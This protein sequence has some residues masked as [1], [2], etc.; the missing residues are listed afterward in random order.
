MSKN[1]NPNQKRRGPAAAEGRS[2]ALAGS[3]SASGGSNPIAEF[4]ASKSIRETIESVAIAFVLA[5]LFRTFEAEAFVIPTGSM[6]HTL[7]GQH[8]DVQCE[9]CGYAHT[10][11]AS[12]SQIDGNP[13]VGTV[14]PMCRYANLFAADD[15]NHID[16]SGD[17]IIV[18]KF[19]YDLQ[20][21]QRWDVIVFK[22]PY[23]A[24]QNYIKRLVGL[25]NE[26]IRLVHGDVWTKPKDAPDS[27]FR[28]ARKPP[29]KV[30]SMQQ[31]VHDTNFTPAALVKN[32]RWPPRW[33]PA[34]GASGA[35]WTR[36][37][38][39][40]TVNKRELIRST[41]N[42]A[43]D[44][45]GPSWIRY[46]HVTPNVGMDWPRAPSFEAADPPARLI[47]DFY[48]YNASIHASEIM[49][50]RGTDDWRLTNSWHEKSDG[51]N[52]VGDLTLECDV[53]VKSEAGLLLLELVK[54]GCHYRCA[55]DVKSGEALLS[56]V[57]VDGAAHGFSADD[58]PGET[59]AEVHGATA[60]RGPGSYKLR[61]SN[62]D[63]QL[64]LWV[65][66]SVVAFDGPTTYMPDRHSPAWNDEDDGDL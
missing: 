64:L 39:P 65:N 4:F 43:G 48:S 56:I 1:K 63:Q 10:A 57:D 54:A 36:D 20:E 11:G 28:I 17:R 31:C 40:T 34:P 66:D 12:E 14:C 26:S 6:A 58:A 7:M 2:G 59:A 50:E 49:E 23:N 9:Q 29:A 27:A 5:F 37:D 19:I 38:Q 21:P 8:K 32:N 55:I 16:H 3:A 45:A 24:K 61:L 30:L 60:V 33:N 62:F 47:T 22:F 42:A 46:R 35:G 53:E 52:W 25:P 41:F 18:S 44:A 51:S 13:V 15:R